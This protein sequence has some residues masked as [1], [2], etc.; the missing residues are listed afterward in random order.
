MTFDLLVRNARLVSPEG[1]LPCS[2]AV[3]QGAIAAILELD[4]DIPATRILDAAGRYLLPGLI[5]THVHLGNAGQSFEDDCRTESMAGA[6]GGITTMLVYV[7]DRGSY[8]DSFDRYRAAVGQSYIDMS[9]HLGIVRPEH[10]EEI[11]AY[12]EKLGIRSFKAFMAYKGGAATPSGIQGVTDGELFWYFTQ[13][14][15]VPGAIALVH[16]ENMEIIE[17]FQSKYESTGRQDTAAWS[18][19]RPAFGELESIQRALSFAREAGVHFAIP[20]LSV[21]IGSE[22]LREKQVGN[23]R[24]HVE[25]CPHYLALDQDTDRGVAGKVN[26]PIREQAQVD[27]MWKRL[28]DGTIDFIGSDHCPFTRATKGNELWSARSGITG[29]VAMI[30]PVLLTDGY[31]RG[32]LTLSKIV[33]MASARPA[34]LFGLYPR[35][36]TIQVGSDADFVIVDIDQEVTVS[37]AKLNTVSDFTPYDGYQAHGW[38]AVTVVG[39]NVVYQDGEIVAREPSGQY[40]TRAHTLSPTGSA[41]SIA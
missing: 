3:R 11:P 41:R 19:A 31:H 9:F 26:P 13:V 18:S 12:G 1:V 27:A 20:H 7:I 10:I 14:A 6:T 8:L 32:R 2:I 5:D 29:G 38:A 33:E 22:F 28:V 39:G 21:G 4:S 36:G 25:T 35:K 17:W 16:C 37:A 34:K 23:A 24:V 40:L 30:L 15:K